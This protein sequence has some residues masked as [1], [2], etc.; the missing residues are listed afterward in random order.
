[1]TV[2][3]WPGAASGG[4]GPSCPRS[5][6]TP[7]LRPALRPQGAGR[8]VAPAPGIIWY[9]VIKIGSKINVYPQIL[10]LLCAP[11]TRVGAAWLLAAKNRSQIILSHLIDQYWPS[12]WRFK[13]LFNSI[14]TQFNVA[15]IDTKKKSNLSKNKKSIPKKKVS[16][17]L[18]EQ[19]TKI[20]TDSVQYRISS[21]GSAHQ[22]SCSSVHTPDTW[23]L[24][25]VVITRGALSLSC[26]HS[27]VFTWKQR[28]LQS[29]TGLHLCH[30]MHTKYYSSLKP[31]HRE[32]VGIQRNILSNQF[33]FSK[34]G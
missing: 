12:H 10:S 21:D 13:I 14:M 11:L 23:T 29:K 8:L 25:I 6:C 33:E 24:T 32:F 18:T 5:R 30:W 34:V 2:R 26:L 1:M 16:F 7:T 3:T 17:N 20:W 31:S 15:A 9:F 22:G 28:R 27:M 4:W 19:V